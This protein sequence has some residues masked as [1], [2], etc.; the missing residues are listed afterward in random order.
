MYASKSKSKQLML[1]PSK[2]FHNLISELPFI[3]MCLISLIMFFSSICIA[4]S[5][6]FQ[7]ENQKLSADVSRLRESES[8]LSGRVDELEQVIQ[9]SIT[10]LGG[11]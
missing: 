6:K 4:S 3:K 11:K 10:G 5:S 8:F 7:Q 1:C 2:L 9:N